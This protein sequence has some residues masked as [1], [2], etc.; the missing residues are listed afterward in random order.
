ME[1]MWISDSLS[2]TNMTHW[3]E[4]LFVDS[5]GGL[6]RATRWGSSYILDSNLR[7]SGNKVYKDESVAFYVKSIDSNKVEISSTGYYGLFQRTEQSNKEAVSQQLKVF[8]QND[9][10]KRRLEGIWKLTKI[11]MIEDTLYPT[12]YIQSLKTEDFWGHPVRDKLFLNFEKSGEFLIQSKENSSSYQYIVSGE[13]VV[14]FKS[15]YNINMKF[16]ITNDTLRLIHLFPSHIERILY[17]E[18]AR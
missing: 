7:I 3:R 2:L 15:D 8:K 5:T 1:G 18:R 16:E 9:L 4:F 12:S 6:I 11:E 17:F 13:E 10:G 14:L